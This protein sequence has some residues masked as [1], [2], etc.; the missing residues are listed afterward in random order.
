MI[1]YLYGGQPQS[2]WPNKHPLGVFNGLTL[3]NG[4]HDDADLWLV[5]SLFL[6]LVACLFAL[7]FTLTLLL[8]RIITLF[9]CGTI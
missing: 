6:A 9:A 1:G 7:T 2:T 4:L 3:D 8:A 5:T